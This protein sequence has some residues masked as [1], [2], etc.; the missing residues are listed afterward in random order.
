MALA[1]TPASLL[2]RA[3]WSIENKAIN[4]GIDQLNF[5]GKS[6]HR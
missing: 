3:E 4:E 6:V 2:H 5:I 1:D